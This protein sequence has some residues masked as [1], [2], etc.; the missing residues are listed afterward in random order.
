MDATNQRMK[1]LATLL[2]C[3]HQFGD[4]RAATYVEADGSRRDVLLATCHLCGTHRFDNGDGTRSLLGANS[5]TTDPEKA[6]SK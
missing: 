1:D 3:R 2:M 5:I 4:T 6:A